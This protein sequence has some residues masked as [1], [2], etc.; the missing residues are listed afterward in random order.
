MRKAA[1]TLLHCN[2]QLTIFR[3]GFSIIAR[4]GFQLVR[5]VFAYIDL[6]IFF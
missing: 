1:G 2:K 4:L 3:K 6:T 5:I